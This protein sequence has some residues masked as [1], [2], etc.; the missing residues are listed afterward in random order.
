MIDTPMDPRTLAVLF[1]ASA[2]S[3]VELCDAVHAVL[4]EDARV[5]YDPR[6]RTINL[7]Q[8]ELSAL[9]LALRGQAG[10]IK[11]A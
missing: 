4:G 3:L 8:S 2:H 7:G 10:A 9:L 11:D 1:N 5:F 6:G